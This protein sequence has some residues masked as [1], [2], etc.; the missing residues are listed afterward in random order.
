[1][2]YSVYRADEVSVHE[3]AASRLSSPTHLEAVQFVQAQDQQLLYAVRNVTECLLT[4]T[5]F[6]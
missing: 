6:V 2:I 3:R 4:R 5:L 1:M